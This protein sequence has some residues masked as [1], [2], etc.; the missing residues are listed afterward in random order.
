MRKKTRKALMRH[1]KRRATSRYAVSLTNA[2]INTI[3]E[4]IQQ[5]LSLFAERIST[6]RSL[7][8]IQY[9]D[10]YIRVIYDKAKKT[11]AT[12]LPLYD[13]KGKNQC[14]KKQP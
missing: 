3:T 13:N 5:G 11:T 14:Q 9:N 10:K 12:F 7:H 6:N 8:I 1:S 4:R 2:E